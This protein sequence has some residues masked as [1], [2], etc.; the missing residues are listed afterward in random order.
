MLGAVTEPLDINLMPMMFGGLSLSSSPVG[1][2]AVI[3][4]MLDFSD[5][6]QITP[7]TEHFPMERVNDAMEH[8]R[9]GNARYRIVLNN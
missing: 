2:P 4:D 7:V 5:R 3:R 9:S 8:L 1:S 6:H